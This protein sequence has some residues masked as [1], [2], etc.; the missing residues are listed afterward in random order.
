MIAQFGCRAPRAMCTSQVSSETDLALGLGAT[1]RG[2][3]PG[4]TYEYSLGDGTLLVDVALQGAH[5]CSNE[6]Q[7]GSRVGG[8]TSMAASH[9]VTASAR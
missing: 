7:Y 4:R 9:S 8:S 3:G 5:R 6:L 1:R 2:G